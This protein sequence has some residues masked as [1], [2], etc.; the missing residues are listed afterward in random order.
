MKIPSKLIKA[1]KSTH[2]IVI[3]EISGDKSTEFKM[4]ILI[5][6]EGGISPLLF[7]V[8]IDKIIKTLK[9]TT[10]QYNRYRN[11]LK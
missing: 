4:K 7:V 3:I 2:E 1:L 11:H 8:L 5:K 9:K 6:Q 10:L